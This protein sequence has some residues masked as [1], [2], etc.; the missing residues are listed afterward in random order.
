MFATGRSLSDTRAHGK[1]SRSCAARR[2]QHR[3]FGRT[4]ARGHRVPSLRSGRAGSCQ[5]STA[6]HPGPPPAIPPCSTALSRAPR[7]LLLCKVRT[8]T[9]STSGT[10]RSFA[11][12]AIDV[13]AF[14]VQL[15]EGTP[16][17][18]PPHRPPLC[19]HKHPE[20][21]PA[22]AQQNQTRSVCAC[23]LSSGIRPRMISTSDGRG[24]IS[25]TEVRLF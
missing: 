14:C 19:Q 9:A 21:E 5:Q 15:R 25:K 3:R 20:R 2:R 6:Q 17:S 23:F 16:T 24:T 4:A 18:V 12:A 1:Q 22:A 13:L 11:W 10:V 7:F 8:A